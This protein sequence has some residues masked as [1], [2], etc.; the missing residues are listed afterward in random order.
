MQLK[1]IEESWTS[2][3]IRSKNKGEH[4]SRSAREGSVLR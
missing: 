3:F 4:N 2:K 1:I